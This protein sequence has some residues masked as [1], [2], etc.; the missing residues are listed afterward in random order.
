M[1]MCMTERKEGSKF[2]F[3]K[4]KKN[5]PIVRK[6]VGQIRMVCLDR[7]IGLGF[8]GALRAIEKEP[9]VSPGSFGRLINPNR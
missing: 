4:L 6:R 3:G 7:L 5:L 8:L 2:S 9:G 1:G